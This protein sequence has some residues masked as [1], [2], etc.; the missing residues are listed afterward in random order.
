MC[1]FKKKWHVEPR[2]F[3]ND[4]CLSPIRSESPSTGI[5]RQSVFQ[6]VGNIFYANL[7]QFRHCFH[8]TA[9]YWNCWN[10]QLQT[11]VQPF[12][13][14][15]SSRVV[16]FHAERKVVPVLNGAKV[17]TNGPNKCLWMCF[18][19]CG[20]FLCGNRSSGRQKMG[21]KDTHN[22]IRAHSEAIWEMH[23]TTWTFSPAKVATSSLRLSKCFWSALECC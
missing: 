20:L 13:E 7:S 1:S 23:F 5:M 18:F 14:T 19:R 8:N 2:V 6:F 17:H 10:H 22:V 4:T 3:G 12:Q 21:V 9:R 11:V 15:H 16:W